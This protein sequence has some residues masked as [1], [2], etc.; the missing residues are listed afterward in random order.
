VSTLLSPIGIQNLVQTYE[1]WVLFGVGM[2]ESTGLPMPGETALVT[3][4]AYAGA[5]HQ[6]GIASVILVA[7]TASGMLFFR[8]HEQALEQ[9]AEAALCSNSNEG[10]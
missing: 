9:R 4:A 3:A 10:G 5:T 2:L 8:H 1:L 7:A 6:I